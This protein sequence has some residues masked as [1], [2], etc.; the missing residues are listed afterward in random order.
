MSWSFRLL[1]GMGLYGLASWNVHSPNAIP[2]QEPGYPL[3][4]ECRPTR[5]IRSWRLHFIPECQPPK[6]SRPSHERE[7]PDLGITCRG[8]ACEVQDQR[9][10][11]AR[12]S[13]VVLRMVGDGSTRELSWRPGVVIFH[14]RRLWFP[15]PPTVDICHFH[16]DFAN[17]SL[18]ARWGTMF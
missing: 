6:R 14:V 15:K 12:Q 16:D 18:L 5:R 11:G 7:L 3:I 1:S 10:E 9:W 2:S 17:S 13:L 4:S 8:H